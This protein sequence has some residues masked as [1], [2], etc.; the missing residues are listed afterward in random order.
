MGMAVVNIIL[1]KINRYRESRAGHWTAATAAEARESGAH[2][3]RRL[4]RACALGGTLL[5][6][7]C[8]TPDITPWEYEREPLP[9]I[10]THHE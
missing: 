7:G 4:V 3:L 6:M 5:A 2:P 9:P 1:P 8:A 10:T